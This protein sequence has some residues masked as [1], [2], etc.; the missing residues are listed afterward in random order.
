[1]AE[2][3]PLRPI[4]KRWLECI[5]TA[6]KHKKPFSEDAAEAMGVLRWRP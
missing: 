5:K 2:D 4:V 1:M 3:M 6:E